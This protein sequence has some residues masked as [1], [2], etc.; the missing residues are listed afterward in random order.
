MAR[1]P[2]PW[3]WDDEQ[4]WYVNYQ[5]KRRFLGK[6]PEGASRPRKSDKTGRWNAP[7]EIETAFVRLLGGATATRYEAPTPSPHPPP[8][9]QVVAV[10]DDF[11]TWCKENREPITAKRY[12]QF[13]QDFV[14]AAG[15]DGVLFGI[16]PCSRL[17]SRHVTAWL[18]GRPTWG[19]TTKKNAITALQAGFNWAVQNRGLERNPIKGMKKPE[20]KRRSD[21]VTPAE[22]DEMIE[23]VGDGNFRDLLIVSYDCGARPFEVKDLERRHFQEDK[24]RAVIPADEAKGRKHPR[25]LLPHREEHGDR[26]PPM[27]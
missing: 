12:A 10:L 9:D 19:P 7:A 25:D 13:C 6:H 8:E 14:N 2:S 20:A 4:G 26:L 24:R 16:L 15:E 3:W 5:G 27:R 1:K 22:F 11:L 23:V 17:T 18:N 21:V